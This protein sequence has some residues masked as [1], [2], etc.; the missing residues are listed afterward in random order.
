MADLF[1]VNCIIDFWFCKDGWE[2]LV[3]QLCE[4]L[5][6]QLVF[7]DCLHHINHCLNHAFSVIV[8]TTNVAQQ[9]ST[10]TTLHCF[11]P[12]AKVLEVPIAVFCKDWMGTA[13]LCVLSSL[14]QLVQVLHE[15]GLYFV[16]LLVLRPQG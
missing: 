10:T 1:T 5:E 13:L 6:K 9:N 12:Q 16:A 4:P 2:E 14:F 3:G 15:L 7:V 8:K 11:M